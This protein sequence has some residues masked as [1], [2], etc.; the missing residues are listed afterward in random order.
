MKNFRQFLQALPSSTTKVVVPGDENDVC[1]SGDTFKYSTGYI[2][3]NFWL[4]AQ[5]F[6]ATIES[7]SSVWYQLMVEIRDKYS[8]HRSSL[9]LPKHLLEHE[10]LKC[11]DSQAIVTASKIFLTH[12][13]YYWVPRYLLSI[14]EDGIKGTEIALFSLAK[15]HLHVTQPNYY[16]HILRPENVKEETP[17]NRTSKAEKSERETSKDSVNQIDPRASKE[18]R[19]KS[20]KRKSKK[21]HFSDAAV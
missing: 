14:K 21:R 12:L 9:Q 17:S 1:A 7:N 16:P 20:R 15:K 4:D 8:H 18:F 6:Q 11:W 2:I 10:S 13:R 5:R 3:Y 19:R